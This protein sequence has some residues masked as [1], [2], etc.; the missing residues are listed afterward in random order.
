MPPPQTSKPTSKRAMSANI[1]ENM[2]KSQSFSGS[3]SSPS[4]DQKDDAQGKMKRGASFRFPKGVEIPEELK[5]EKMSFKEKPTDGK[6]VPEAGN[7]KS[8]TWTEGEATKP[9]SQREEEQAPS[10]KAT[11]ETQGSHQ[12]SRRRSGS[13]QSTMPTVPEE[14]IE[15]GDSEQQHQQQRSSARSKDAGQSADQQ[16]TTPPLKKSQSERRWAPPHPVAKPEERKPA[17]AGPKVSRSASMPHTQKQTPPPT[18]AE[19]GKWK[20]PPSPQPQK[21]VFRLETSP[22]LPQNIIIKNL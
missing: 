4:L 5:K 10:Y 17:A 22:F 11:D 1:L 19:K 15:A 8:T 2:G 13:S 18:E 16:K 12:K 6:S 3:R 20:Q 14:D 9:T 21:K 7:H